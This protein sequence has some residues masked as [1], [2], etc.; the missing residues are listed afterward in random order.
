MKEAG[1]G[2]ECSLGI[3]KADMPQDT[4]QT[5]K[6]AIKSGPPVTSVSS[7]ILF[8]FRHE[9]KEDNRE[10]SKMRQEPLFK[11]RRNCC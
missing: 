7:H 5:L 9:Q 10:K 2:S 4:G 11:G 6:K 3:V 8:K 1:R